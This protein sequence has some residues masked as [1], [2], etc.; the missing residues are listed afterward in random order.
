MS[1]E[2]PVIVIALLLSAILAFITA[3]LAFF[4]RVTPASRYLG[5]HALGT[6]IW[7]LFYAFEIVTLDLQQKSL[8][9]NLKYIGIVTI[10]AA[11]LLLAL[12]FTHRDSKIIYRTGLLL[13]IEPVATLLI[14][15]SN[16]WHHWFVIQTTTM[17]SGDYLVR[18]YIHGP[19]FDFNLVYSVALIMIAAGVLTDYAYRIGRHRRFQTLMILF[20][21][22]VPIVMMLLHLT[23]PHAFVLNPSSIMIALGLPFIA[24]GLL[25][26]RILDVVPGARDLVIEQLGD[27]VMI[28][29]RSD[30]L[31]DL[32]PAAAKF[33]NIQVEAAIGEPLKDLFPA[34]QQLNPSISI[35]R[36]ER[37]IEL[38]VSGASSCFEFQV[39]LLRTWRGMP[40]GR[41][42][43]LHEITQAK[44]LE[45][46]LRQAKEQAEEGAR[47]KALFLAN[48][49]HEIRT[50]LNA[51]IGMS[52]VL[53][54]SQLPV[55][56]EE[57]V[58]IIRASGN[59]LLDLINQILDYSR[60]EADRVDFV[61]NPFS[62]YCCLEESLDIIQPAAHQ[63]ADGLNLQ[64]G[65][66]I[67]DGLI[68]D[69]AHL[70]QVLINL[71]ANAVKFTRAGRI[72]LEVTAVQAEE[73]L[74]I[75][76]S[77]LDTGIGIPPEQLDRIFES[78]NQV[79]Q[80]QVEP[81][82]GFGL[83]LAICRRLVNLMKGR[84]WAE[85]RADNTGTVFSAEIPFRL[86]P[87]WT[88]PHMDALR[89][90]ITGKRI[91]IYEPVQMVCQS[92][93]NLLLDWP[94]DLICMDR[95][96]N[97]LAYLQSDSPV[98]VVVTDIP[99]N[100]CQS[101]LDFYH[102]LQ[103]WPARA[104]LPIVLLAPSGKV[105]SA[106]VRACVSGVMYQPFRPN[107]FFQLL[108][109]AMEK[110]QSSAR[111][112]DLDETPATE[113]EFALLYPHKILVADDNIVN[114]R[115]IFYYLTQ[116]GY[117]IDVATSGREVL[118]MLA[119]G[120]YDLV[121]MDV[122]MPEMDG[123]ETAR[124]IRQ[125]VDLQFQP[126]IIA[127]TAHRIDENSQEFTQSDF[128]GI[129][130]KPIQ[131][132]ELKAALRRTVQENQTQ[133]S[134]PLPSRDMPLWQEL[135]S[136]GEEIL[137]SF[138]EEAREQYQTLCRAVAVKD[139]GGLREAA[140]S[141]KS[142][143]GYLGYTHLVEI[144]VQIEQEAVELRMPAAALLATL[145]NAMK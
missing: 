5:L 125:M 67:P 105:V 138:Q 25:R 32:N 11:L 17:F 141:L 63:Q 39:L 104:N 23:S 127:L 22:L 13:L 120:Q 140:H 15:W 93:H 84:I 126:Q 60:I 136:E 27:I 3:V 59:S 95:F 143:L 75:R 130:D 8:Y 50:P 90:L 129:V 61:E 134:L 139:F 37:E 70:R 34:W 107:Q 71:L 135:G 24:Y 76:F 113:R 48:L 9:F 30:I 21:T 117:A 55:E 73:H 115:V 142:S 51:V 133:K 65:P 88:N 58:Q 31:I 122:R 2:V 106:E 81:F 98:D 41:L 18:E 111:T 80:S 87:E 78:F 40:Y 54:G 36:Y 118:S 86:A 69:V 85:N 121:M 145:D 53:M 91:L 131:I 97:V 46:N 45:D 56:L 12:K 123:F 109:G 26:F 144:C 66:A 100:D 57:P 128:D 47:A 19:W 83:G 6:A 77:V 42:V 72:D 68:G 33:L 99:N 89:P 94:L 74:L 4:R 7:C 110:S 92:V 64:I 38:A 14:I 82:E 1:Y 119:D 96:E 112:G 20:G 116:L 124:R 137:R 132:S 103:Q 44:R 102:Q 52:N 35:E 62:L 101:I 28:L 49:S 114:R 79:D 10:P 16:A 43:F 108:L 29:N